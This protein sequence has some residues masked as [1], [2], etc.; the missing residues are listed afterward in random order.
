MK[1]RDY[2]PVLFLC[3]HRAQPAILRRHPRRTIAVI[4]IVLSIISAKSISGID[5]NNDGMSDVWQQ[6]Y[7]VPSADANLDYDGTGLTNSQ[8]S[9]LGLDPR[10]PNSRFHLEI[11]SDSANN[12]LRLRLDTVFGK[13]YQLESSSDLRNW[14]SFNSV[15]TG[16]GNTVEISQSLPGAQ[17]FFRARFA[18]DVDADGD[19]LT[20]WEEHELGTRD[21]SSDSDGDG[22]PDAWEVTHGLNPNLNDANSDSDGD[23]TSNVKEFQRG[24]DPSDFYN[25]RPPFL[26]VYAGGD[27]RGDP[28][29]ML[30]V[31]ISVIVNY[32]TYNAP[33]TFSVVQGHALLAPDSTGLSTPQSTLSIRS[34]G[35]AIGV[36]GSS[37]VAQVW[38]Y[39]PSIANEVSVIRATA[40]TGAKVVSVDTTAVTVDSSLSP[41]A[42]FEATPTSAT[43][44]EIHWTTS[45]S[46][47]TLQVSTNGGATWSNV[48]VAG[49]GVGRIIVTGLQPNASV[50]FRSFSGGENPTITVDGGTVAMPDSAAGQP[51][52]GGSSATASVPVTP[53]S[54]PVIEGEEKSFHLGSVGFGGFTRSGYHYLAKTAVLSYDPDDYTIFVDTIDPFTGYLTSQPPRVIGRGG[55]FFYLGEPNTGEVTKSDTLKVTESLPNDVDDNGNPVHKILTVTLSDRD[56][57]TLLRQ[58][59]EG[60]IPAFENKFT[61]GFEYADFYV[62]DNGYEIIRLQYRWKVNADPNLTVTW[63][64]QFTPYDGGPLH[65]EVH[66]WVTEGASADP[67]APYP[68]DPRYQN[69]GRN[70]YYDVILLQANLA[71]DGN[72]DGQMSFADPFVR[73]ADK[74]TSDKPYRFWLNDD[75]DTEVNHNGEGGSPTGPLEQEQ[76]PAPRPDSSLHQIASKRNLEDFARLWIDLSGATDALDWGMEHGLKWK[77]VSGSPAINIYPSADGEGSTSYL[78]SDAAAQTQI[79]SSTFNDVVRDKHNK[80]AVDGNGTFI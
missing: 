25:G 12:Q 76:V 37:Y 54:H 77:N 21:N 20:A 3:L 18:G 65:H 42:S 8:K 50:S 33:L 48:A 80:Q 36:Y 46:T 32:N 29:T 17:M 56:D 9:L 78:T 57:E 66:R 40:V 47:T 71:V 41:P 39:L 68:I 15:I 11:V 61:E 58:N 35:R 51:G 6:K 75:D 14:A 19:G 13:L 43:T 24:T 62:N 44:V 1:R 27:Q 10:D 69:A 34:T 63:D 28:G 74:T 4:W 72:R 59:A 79:G 53:L 70:G 49:P 5:V 38:V 31:P 16:T 67:L 2:A 45:P 60:R 23:G 26:G 55:S 52:G 30:P 22:M 64:V 73:D 7:S